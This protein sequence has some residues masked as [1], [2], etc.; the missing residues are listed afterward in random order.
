MRIT[1]TLAALLLCSAVLLLPRSA[2][3]QAGGPQEPTF[4][5]DVAPILYK[6]CVNCHRPGQ[7]APMSLINC[8]EVRPWARSIKN[9]VET[10]TM[11]PWHLDRRIGIQGFKNDLCRSVAA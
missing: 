5:H 11:P 7:I 1:R 9:K 6:S 10:R 8:Q 4:A 3:A 2:F